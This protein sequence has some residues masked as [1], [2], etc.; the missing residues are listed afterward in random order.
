MFLVVRGQVSLGFQVTTAGSSL[1]N[2]ASVACA[3]LSPDFNDFFS[4]VVPA[5]SAIFTSF[6]R[7]YCNPTII[8]GSFFALA[9]IDEM[10]AVESV[11]LSFFDSFIAV[12]RVVR[13][14]ISRKDFV[15]LW[16]EVKSSVCKG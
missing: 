6:V 13:S 1:A 10:L 5:K 16:R 8:R 14:M 4:L 9:K 12:L 11:F 3:I 2:N 15:L 7:K